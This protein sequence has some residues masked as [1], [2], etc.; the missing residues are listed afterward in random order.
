MQRGLN[1]GF[2]ER[3]TICCS[4][5]QSAFFELKMRFVRV[6]ALNIR[7]HPVNS[8]YRSDIVLR[9]PRTPQL[10]PYRLIVGLAYLNCP[11]RHIFPPCKHYRKILM[12]AYLQRNI[13]AYRG[14]DGA[15][16]HDSEYREP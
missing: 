5:E 4:Y 11:C 10:I 16:S 14:L 9:F 13:V 6:P 12:S 7:L 1:R 8:L 15:Y 2:P 3:A